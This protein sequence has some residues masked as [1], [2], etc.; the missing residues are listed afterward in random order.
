MK[1]A[2]DLMIK[3]PEEVPVLQLNDNITKAR[4]YF[5]EYFFTELYVVDEK[6]TLYGYIDITDVL[7]ITDT[8]SNV[9]IEGFMKEAPTVAPEDTLETVALTIQNATTGSV[10]VLG[11]NRE[12]VGAIL[13]SE[14]FPLLINRHELRGKVRDYMTTDVV[15]CAPEDTVQKIYTLIVDSDLT[16]FP[17]ERKKSLLGIIS[18]SDLVKNGRIRSSL[19]N[20]AKMTVQSIMTT[21]AFS[22]SP[23]EEVA[24]A[25]EKLVKH[26]ISRLP[27]IENEAIIGI[28]DRHDVL[29][30]LILQG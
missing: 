8:K 27:V 29:K 22:I 11:E 20:A 21:P 16:A 17:V 4:K 7:R 25:A 24:V 2:S 28:I 18:R 10:A 5:R 23:E 14:L 13:L 6:N 3:I 30:S 12:I 26:D 15:T 9:T 1:K 19:G